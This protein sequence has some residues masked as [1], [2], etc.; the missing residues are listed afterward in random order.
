MDDVALKFDGDECIYFPFYRNQSGYGWMKFGEKNIGAHVYALTFAVGEKPTPH[1]EC[2]HTCGNGHLGCV[3][4]KHLYWGTRAENVQDSI[5][6]G[7]FWPKNR[8]S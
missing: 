7:T 6:A 1:H 2:C 8:K 4:P 3:N 5:D